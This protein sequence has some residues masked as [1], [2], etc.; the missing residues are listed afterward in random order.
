MNGDEVEVGSGGGGIEIWAGADP[1][2]AN[3]GSKSKARSKVSDRS[4]RSTR[5]EAEA[6][7]EAA[8]ESPASTQARSTQ[9][10]CAGPMV[11]R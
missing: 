2:E 6:K 5:A 1:F 7:S 4:V 3:S 10:N 8:G 9:A 11:L